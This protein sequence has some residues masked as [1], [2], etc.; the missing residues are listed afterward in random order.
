MSDNIQINSSVLFFSLLVNPSL[1]LPQD[2]DRTMFLFVTVNKS[3]VWPAFTTF[4]FSL[5]IG[6]AF[7]SHGAFLALS[8]LGLTF[9]VAALLSGPPYMMAGGQALIDARAILRFGKVSG[10]KRRMHRGHARV[11]VAGDCTRWLVSR[12]TSSSQTPIFGPLHFSQ[13]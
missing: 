13:S 3:I 1:F 5:P 9:T 7:W 6:T 12:R 11:L 4:V 8:Q 10:E 2:T